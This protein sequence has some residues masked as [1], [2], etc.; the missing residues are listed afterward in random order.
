MLTLTPEQWEAVFWTL[1]ILTIFA[2]QIA[3]LAWLADK[4]GR[5]FPDAD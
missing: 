2:A 5:H 1:A 4:L 3:P